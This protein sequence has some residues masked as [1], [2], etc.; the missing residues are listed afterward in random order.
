MTIRLT[1]QTSRLTTACLFAFF[2]AAAVDATE[3]ERTVKDNVI[4][5]Q[6][7]P[8]VQIK[9]PAYAE[10]VGADRWDLYDIADCELHAFVKTDGQKKVQRVFWVQFE[11]YLPTKPDLH[12]TYDSPRRA[13]IGG[14]DFY[15]DTAVAS[16]EQKP[17]ADSDGEHIR[18]LITRRGYTWPKEF[19][20]VRF[21][22]LLDEAKRKELM[23]IYGEDLGPTG[24]S[25]NDLRKGGRAH[26]RWAQIEEEM[27]ERARQAI[28]VS[29]GS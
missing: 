27:I 3:P 11:Q 29:P 23:I 8:A 17:K 2:L 1:T 28:V 10:Y 6:R 15:V 18:A 25:A 16:S 4:T 26:D 5:S 21:V 19:M 14:L 24:F 9:L 12:H 22:H 7:D 20:Y 13:K